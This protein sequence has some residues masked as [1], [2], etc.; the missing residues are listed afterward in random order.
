M[1]FAPCYQRVDIGSRRNSHAPLKNSKRPF[2][3][4]AF[5]AGAA[6]VILGLAGRNLDRL[7]SRL[8]DYAESVVAPAQAL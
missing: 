5:E 1:Y 2:D 4:L 7:L 8:A 3:H 6:Q